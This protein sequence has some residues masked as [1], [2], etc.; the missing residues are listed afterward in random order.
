[1]DTINSDAYVYRSRHKIRMK[2]YDGALKDLNSA[3]KIRF[4]NSEAYAERAFVKQKST[5]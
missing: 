4:T 3:I 1:M 5:I 2:D